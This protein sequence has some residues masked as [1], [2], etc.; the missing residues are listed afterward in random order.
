MISQSNFGKFQDGVEGLHV[1]AGSTSTTVK[2][3][4]GVAIIGGAPFAQEEAA[5]ANIAVSTT[6][7]TYTL[8]MNV[9]GA[10]DAGGNSLARFGFAPEADKTRDAINGS[11]SVTQGRSIPLAVI[12]VASNVV[13]AIDNSIKLKP[14]GGASEYSYRNNA[15]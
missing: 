2:V 1:I 6:N 15:G 8:Y 14:I 12:T 3:G 7:G 9:P 11:K 13:S 5:I 10:L 4:V